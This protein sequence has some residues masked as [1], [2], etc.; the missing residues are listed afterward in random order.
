MSRAITVDALRVL[1]VIVPGDL[2]REL[3]PNA[4]RAI[5]WG[6]KSKMRAGVKH[7]AFYATKEALGAWERQHGPWEP[8]QG[9]TEV[10]IVIAW[11]K[12]RRI[13][14]QDNALASCKAVIDQLAEAGV[15]AND[16]FCEYPP[17]IQ[18]RDEDGRGFIRLVVTE[19]APAVGAEPGGDA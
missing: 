10:Q 15:I 1:T 7:A 2:P 18:M 17:L 8:L 5:H 12:G 13:M 11:G 19:L 3:S 14:D 4:S 9:R 16:R 6:T